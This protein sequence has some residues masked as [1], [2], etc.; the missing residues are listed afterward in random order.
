MDIDID[1]LLAATA[2][3]AEDGYSFENNKVDIDQL[4]DNTT[5]W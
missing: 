4:L 3:I 5:D 2:E 1:Q